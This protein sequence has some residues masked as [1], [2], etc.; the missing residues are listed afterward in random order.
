MDNEILSRYRFDAEG[1]AKEF[2]VSYYKTHE[3]TFPVNIFKVLTDLDVPF[4]FRSF[5][6]LEGL[7][8]LPE[9][10]DDIPLIVLNASRPIQR[11]R[12]T[13]AHELCHYLKD[14]NLDAGPLCV[15]N[16]KNRIER[17]ADRF[18]AAFLMPADVM[19]DKLSE[20]YCGQSL[21]YDSVLKIAEF[22]GVSFEACLF[23]IATLYEYVLPVNFRDKYKRY[24][25]NQRRVHFGF[26]DYPLFRDLIDCWPA[27]FLGMT[28]DSIRYA[29][30]SNFIFND[31]R[32]ERVLS[33]KG[34]VADLIT[35]LRRNGHDS[36]FY[37]NISGPVAELLGHSDVYDFIL[38]NYQED[39]AISIYETTKLN[40]MLF[41]H[42]RFPDFG[43]R[44]RTCNTLVLG[45]KFETV[46]YSKIIDCLQSLDAEVKELEKNSQNLSNSEKI[47]RIASIHH[48]LTKIHPFYDGNGRTS[49]AFMNIQLLRYGLCPIY[50]ED[51]DKDSYY[52]ALKEADA[53]NDTR[54]LESVICS[55]MV[56]T[57]AE[58][59]TDSWRAGRN[60]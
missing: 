7:F 27:M 4:V 25:P 45:A 2:S 52:E 42:S 22:F 15:T 48:Q 16:S 12:F 23:R 44:T 32:V 57:H 58:I 5:D 39:R 41:S 11:I 60:R 43:G 1:L 53:S 38:S 37:A 30:K 56:K 35:D 29:F 55:A 36:E 14:S 17:Y 49:R 3:R 40:R 59:Y 34:Q 51:K 47:H 20:Y 21:S 13:A 54:I 8:I 18:A 31:S 33:E 28:N 19:K 26:N 46:D 24:R 50:I 6:K 9:S 10:Q